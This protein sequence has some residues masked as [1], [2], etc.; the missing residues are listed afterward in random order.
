M[1]RKKNSVKP[2]ALS[3]EYVIDSDSDGLTQ[4]DSIN[5]KNSSNETGSRHSQK[6]QKSQGTPSS[7]SAVPAQSSGSESPMNEENN[8]VETPSSS[9]KAGSI[10]TESDREGAAPAKQKLHKRR[11]ASVYDV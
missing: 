11:A 10:E 5:S 7:K 4:P 2:L 1:A 8:D 6:K 3:E 9:S